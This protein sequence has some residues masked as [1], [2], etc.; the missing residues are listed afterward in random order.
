MSNRLTFL[1]GLFDRTYLPKW[2]SRYAK[3]IGQ[4]ATSTEVCAIANGESIIR[5]TH[6]VSASGVEKH[7]E[8]VED[9]AVIDGVT[10]IRKIGL[11]VTFSDGDPAEEL[12][13]NELASGY[14]ASIREETELSS[15]LTGELHR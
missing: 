5:R 6:S 14:L 10:K 11:T 12:A 7:Y 15:L 2:H 4:G 8:S 13:T 1:V 3:E 9:R